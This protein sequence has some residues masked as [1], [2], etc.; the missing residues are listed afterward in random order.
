MIFKTITDDVTGATTQISIFNSTLSTMKRN[1]ASGQGITYSI[2]NGNKLTQ[3]DVQAIISYS[4]ALKNGAS[5]GQAWSANMTNCSVAAKQYVVSAKRAGKSTDELVTGL[6]TVPKATTAASIGLKALSMAGNMLVM[7][8]I[9]E[10]ISAIAT[11]IDNEANRAEYAQERLQEFNSTV[12]ESK[13]K[14]EEQQKWI[15]ENGNRYEELA[16]GVDN[17]GHNVSLTADEF[18]EYQSITKDIADMFP[19]MISGYNDQN[20]AIIK[21]KGNVDALTESYKENVRQ[22]YAS[23]LAKS[24]ETYNDYK[25]AISLSKNQ[26]KYLTELISGK[27][28]LK[29]V[30]VIESPFVNDGENAIQKEMVDGEYTN[31]V[32]GIDTDI[33]SEEIIEEI[34]KE[35]DGIVKTFDQLSPQL[36]QKIRAVLTSANSTITTETSKVKPVLEA[37]I[38]GEDGSSSGYGQLTED[39]K[40]AIRNVISSLDELDITFLIVCFPSSSS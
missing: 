22:A 37:F 23:T 17:Y 9:S 6:K 5:V 24:S 10:A 16:R 25:D 34:K 35:T 36:Q 32:T 3:K 18:S 39:G 20:D 19:N 2:F 26:K 13:N 8:G 21:T 40:Q 11:A 27:L 4:N 14:L 38:Y 29:N 28:Q 7:W 15:E 12:S 1:L 30:G 33:L 31:V